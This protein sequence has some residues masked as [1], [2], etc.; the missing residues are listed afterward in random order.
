MFFVVNLTHVCGVA[1]LGDES[2]GLPKVP[3]VIPGS[4][5]VDHACVFGH[6]QV[7]ASQQPPN[8]ATFR[9]EELQQTPWLIYNPLPII[10]VE[11]LRP[12]T[13]KGGS[14]PSGWIS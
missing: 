4:D 7:L 13:E 8:P 6:T 11:K 2:P 10:Q 1:E 9:T 3:T 14:V 5:A 12:E